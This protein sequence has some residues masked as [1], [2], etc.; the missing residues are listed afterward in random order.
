MLINDV[1]LGIAAGVGVRLSP[2]GKTAYYV[3]WSTGTVSKVEVATAMVTTIMTGLQFPQDVLVDWDDGSMF[4]SERTGAIT[5]IFG[6]R[7]RREVAKPG[8][9][10]H[11]LALYK[12]PAKRF[13]YTVCFDSG[14]LLE[15]D[16]NNGGAIKQICSGLGHPV[17]LVV[18]K[19]NKFAYVTEQDGGALTQVRIASGIKQQLHS[20]MIA[21]FY[22]A[23][24]KTGKALYCVQRDPA[25]NLLKIDL[26]PPITVSTVANGLAWRP[27]GVAP[28]KDDSRIYVCS[29]RELEVLSPKGVPPIKPA[30][31]PFEVHSIEF[32]R[33]QG[34]IPIKHHSTDTPVP[35]PEFIRGARN[36]PACYIAGM[37]PRVKVVLRQLPGFVPGTYTIGAT[38]SL[39]GIRYKDVAPSFNAN[40]LSNPIDFEFMWP[41]YKVVARADVSLN[42]FARRTPG[43]SQVAAVGS[44]VHR[45]FVLLG[46]PTAPWTQPLWVAALDLACGWASGAAS[47]DAAATL[48]TERY[49]A[50]GRVS[51]DTISGSTMYG[52]T[53][54]Q[55]SEMIERLTGGVGLGEKINC[56]DSANTVSTLANLLGCDLWQSRMESSFA[57]NPVIAIGYNVWE[58]P[59]GS[60][61][62]YH[63][64]PWKGLCTQAEHIYD[65]CLK[66]DADGDPTQAPHVP[67]L[68][69]NMLFG[70]CNA[71]NYRKR[72][73]PPNASGCP[74]CQPQPATRQR[75]SIA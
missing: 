26:G 58:V 74:K 9:A 4:V 33:R 52:F 65:G 67:L 69:T 59:F 24:D 12:N 70:D 10:P 47:L 46:N 40:G 19:T 43:P 57:L 31:P 27:S 38:G 63:E 15:I 68:P 62:S 30:Q 64:V 6:G 20:G 41:L 73:C 25:N 17:G 3:E 28:N 22:L 71:M 51:Y 37:L 29:D 75:R 1:V 32:N 34:A 45:I 18:D 44:A 36:E 13:L 66:V 16:L 11:Q 53:T 60:G 23:W 48:I 56:T 49:N 54:F 39:G 8:H 35:A 50:S 61:F 7:E 21:P 42:W 14:Q 2:D 55:L 72:L 5:Q